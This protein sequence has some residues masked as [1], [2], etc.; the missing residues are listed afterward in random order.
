MIFFIFK[1]IILS[2][3]FE[4]LSKFNSKSALQGQKNEDFSEKIS[5]IYDSKISISISLKV[6]KKPCSMPLTPDFN[7]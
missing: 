4:Y 5:Q 7:R 2:I 1:Q 6:K 3:E